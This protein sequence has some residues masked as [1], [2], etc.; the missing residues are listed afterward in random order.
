MRRNENNYRSSIIVELPIF[1]ADRLADLF[2][3]RLQDDLSMQ[4]HIP[5]LV[6]FDG[7]IYIRLYRRAEDDP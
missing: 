6:G 3:L 4:E 1:S 5:E 2:S 7:V